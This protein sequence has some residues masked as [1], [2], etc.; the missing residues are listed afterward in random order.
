M[1]IKK[2]SYCN[3]PLKENF[4]EIEGH[5]FCERCLK[6]FLD[7]IK[8]VIEAN[9]INCEYCLKRFN[10]KEMF[11]V[12]NHYFC[13]EQ[14][15]TNWLNEWKKVIKKTGGMKNGIGKNKKTQ[16]K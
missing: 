13:S 7:D 1:R 15:H 2:C 10:K 16:K 6:V 5:L 9:K 3:E 4:F 14:C 12:K 11:K 8:W